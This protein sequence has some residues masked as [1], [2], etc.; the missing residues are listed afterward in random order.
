MGWTLDQAPRMDGKVVVITGANSGIGWEAAW[1]LASRGAQVVMACRDPGRATEARERLLQ[2]VPDAKLEMLKLDLA[3][4]ASVR[5]AAE[6]LGSRHPELYALVNN[7]G[8]MAIPYRKTED[9]FEMQLSTNHLGHFAL[10]GLLL[11][12]IQGRVVS[13]SSGMHRA[14][15]IHFD[16]LMGEKSYQPWAAY[17]QSK[18]ANL[19]FTAEL[20]L[21]L[22]KVGSP[23][24]AVACHPGYSA[25][26]LQFVAARMENSSF[27]ERFFGLGNA[28]F[29]Q[30]AEMG[31]Q[32]TVYATS[33][34]VEGGD[35]YGP[36]FLEIW[37]APVK[38]S[39]SGAARDA[40]VAKRLWEVSETLTGVHFLD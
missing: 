19:L 36:S 8:V 13:V 35:Y 24:K 29:A 17:G 28:L 26:N 32:P 38:N 18:L 31:A 27:M 3:S 25:T 22:K 4:L 9:G 23:V 6:E 30:S 21:R 10:T 14:G 40:E 2:K 15:R 33:M 1:M 20:D 37:G 34:E 11:P 16:D 7:A 5:A 39:R 12:K